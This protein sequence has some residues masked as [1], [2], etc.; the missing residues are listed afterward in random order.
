MMNEGRTSLEVENGFRQFDRGAE[1]IKYYLEPERPFALRIPVI[2][3]LQKEAVRDIQSDAGE[4]RRGE[5]HISGSIHSPPAA[6]LVSIHLGDF[7]DYINKNWHECSAFHLSAYEMWRLNWIHP[8][9]DG[10]GQCLMFSS[11]FALVIYCR[12][13]LLYRNRSRVTKLTTFMR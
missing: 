5:V 9:T 7:C 3:E 1:I 8:F 10:N 13:P 6:H 12:A 4:L 11:A 2:V